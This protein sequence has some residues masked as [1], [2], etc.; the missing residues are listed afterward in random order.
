MSTDRGYLLPPGDAYT[1][2]YQCAIIFYPNKDEYRRALLGSLDYLGT[3][4]AWERDELKR[5]K[6]AA[7]AWKNA[8][9]LTRECIEMGTCNDI[10]T[11]LTQ[12]EKNTRVC[13]GQTS[14]VTYQD[15]TVVTTVIIPGQGAPPATY[16]ETPVADWDEWT[17]YV[18]Y[19]AHA[20]VDD[21]IDTAEKLDVAISIGGY[22]LDFIA[23]LFS[24]VQWRMVEDI[25][26][27]N[28]SLIQAIFDALGQGLIDNEFA[29]LAVD[30]E[31]NR[32][33][34]VCA[35][36]NGTSLEDAVHAVV[37]DGVLWTVFYQWLDYDTTTA[38]IYEGG[39]P[40]IGY[41]TPL[42][43]QDCDCDLVDWGQ[44]VLQ[45]TLSP[46]TFQYTKTPPHCVYHDTGYTTFAE[47]Y[48]RPVAQ[49]GDIRMTG[50]IKM[51]GTITPNANCVGSTFLYIY[52]KMC[53][54]GAD[55]PYPSCVS[56]PATQIYYEANPDPAIDLVVPFD[57]T[58][59]LYQPYVTLSCRI[60]TRGGVFDYT[61]EIETLTI[62]E[63]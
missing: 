14:Y 56:I 61:A 7:E 46:Y 58:Q 59:N 43:R 4:L 22:V 44:F 29:T 1:E 50:N 38:V 53:Q 41:L 47:M 49:A 36:I 55:H 24:L 63:L 62:E 37:G 42:K 30:F 28:F 60:Y 19:H 12:I 26:P 8:T 25:I 34:I 21:L 32:D 13:C 33:D 16:G 17:E 9:E 15:N 10:L 3:W 11:L 5:G 52:V 27:V 57:I 31:A 39:I 54:N 6:D 48:Y 18:C 51:S 23:H 20:Y 45:S 35:L 40:E 2:D